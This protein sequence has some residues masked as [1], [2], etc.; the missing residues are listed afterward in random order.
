MR[1]GQPQPQINRCIVS[2][3][4]GSASSEEELRLLSVT[5]RSMGDR[6][7]A[8]SAMRRYIARNPNT[9]YAEQFNEYIT[10]E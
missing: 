4:R 8:V 7:N 9:R 10:G 1:S 5:Y 6:A 2:A 3:L